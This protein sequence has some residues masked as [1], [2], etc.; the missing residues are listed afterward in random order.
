MLYVCLCSCDEMDVVENK[1]FSNM[2]SETQSEKNTTAFSEETA[3]QKEYNNKNFTPELLHDPKGLNNRIFYVYGLAPRASDSEMDQFMSWEFVASEDKKHNEWIETQI[4][5]SLFRYGEWCLRAGYYKE[6]GQW[7]IMDFYYH[8]LYTAYVG[9]G[10][11]IG[12]T[13]TYS[14]GDYWLVTPDAF[15]IPNDHRVEI[16]SFDESKQ[17]VTLTFTSPEGES[18]EVYINYE[19]R[20]RCDEDGTPLLDEDGNTFLYQFD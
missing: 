4:F 15:G 14:S 6:T 17:T 10:Q 7:G 8:G 1:E 12:T 20:C 19:K 13:I 11:S 3:N 16:T 18:T 9:M 2:Q 5:T